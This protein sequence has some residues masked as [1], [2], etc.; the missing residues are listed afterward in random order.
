MQ[1]K[2]NYILSY[3][4]ALILIIAIVYP[5]GHSMKSFWIFLT[6]STLL[7]LAYTQYIIGFK[8][9]DL[10]NKWDFLIFP[11]LLNIS[12]YF[13]IAYFP[14]LTAQIP[15]ALFFGFSLNLVYNSLVAIK[16][17]K[18]SLPVTYRNLLMALSIFVVFLCSSLL[19]NISLYWISN[20]LY[21]FLSHV[22]LLYLIGHFL[23]KHMLVAP[24]K[25]S[26]LYNA[27]ISLII[28]EIAT[29]SAFWS[30][31]YPKQGAGAGIP[32]GAIFVLIAYYVLWGLV[33]YM[34]EGRLTKKVTVEFALIGAFSFV[35]VVFTTNWLP[36]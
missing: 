10:K 33:Y 28:S 6:A 3:F 32:I 21:L 25:Y 8:W 20:L 24:N 36:L 1:Q 31:N 18:M 7:N 11:F 35:A 5:K 26:H 16:Y 13:F 30:V 15:M 14:N 27:I 29:T 23:I 34:I 9:A 2:I 17:K 19:I 4:S 22:A 12:A